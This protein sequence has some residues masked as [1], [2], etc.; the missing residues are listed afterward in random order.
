MPQDI[1][2][3]DT[4]TL[5]VQCAAD[6]DPVDGASQ[7]LIGQDLTDRSLYT[8]NRTLGPVGG[9]AEYRTPIVDYGTAY[10]ANLLFLSP[11]FG[12]AQATTGGTSDYY[13]APLHLPFSGRLVKVY[14]WTHGDLFGVGPHGALPAVMPQISLYRTI[15]TGAISRTL[16]GQTD[17]PSGSVLLYESW[18]EL[19]IEGLAE[20]IAANAQ[21]SL[22][23]SG[24]G[25]AGALAG[26][27]HTVDL[28]AEVEPAP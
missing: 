4:W 6:G 28:L 11:S 23:V 16:I 14:A 26:A 7:L 17:D 2:G 21:L 22:R 3:A 19:A 25:G 18:H 8:R 24:E 10:R 15:G 12:L 27:W 1:V 9:V 20:D 5:T 13:E